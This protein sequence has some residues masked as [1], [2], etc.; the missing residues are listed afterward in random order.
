MG[1]VPTPFGRSVAGGTFLNEEAKTSTVNRLVN[2]IREAKP[3]NEATQAL[4][5]EELSRR[6]GRAAGVIEAGS[7]AQRFQAAKGQLVGDL[8]NAQFEPVMPQFHRQD[9]DSLYDMIAE[10]KLRPFEQINTADAL[11]KLLSGTIPTR[12]E[13]DKLEKVFGPELI[14]AVLSKRTLNE[15]AFE[16]IVDILNIPRTLATAFDASAPLRQGVILSVAHPK[17]AGSAFVSMFKAMARP[18]VDD[19]IQEAIENSPRY[20]LMQK[21]KLYLAPGGSSATLSAR[22]EAFMSRLINRI[23]VV[24]QGVQASERGYRTYLNKLRADVFTT[25][26]NNWEKDGLLTDQRAKKL[27]DFLNVAS[28]RGRLGKLE[29]AA[30]ILSIPFFAPRLLTSR[31]QVPL[32][33]F[34]RDK[35]VR[36]QVARDLTAFVGTGLTVLGI[37]HAA[38]AE[39]E[40][41]PRSSDFGKIKIGNQRIDFW[42]GFQPIARYTAQILTG[43]RKDSSGNIQGSFWEG[44]GRR[45]AFERFLR[46]KLSPGGAIVY[47]LYAGNTFMGDELESTPGFVGSEALKRA[48]PLFFQDLYDAAKH[49][50]IKG[51]LLATPAFFGASSQ[52]YIPSESNQFRNLF[53]KVTRQDWDSLLDHE[54][55]ALLEENPELQEAYEKWQD[56]RETL[57]A[58][59]TRTKY[60]RLGDPELVALARTNPALYRERAGQIVHDAGVEYDFAERNKLLPQSNYKQTPDQQAVQGYY[61]AIARATKNNGEVDYEL[62]EQLGTNYL[63][64]LDSK[65]REKVLAE[66]S[67]SKDPTYRELLEDRSKL[68]TYFNAPDE[69]FA[70]AKTDPASAAILQ[71]FRNLSD[72]R[73][74]VDQTLRDAGVPDSEILS[75]RSKIERELGLDKLILAARKEAISRDPATIL[76]LEKWGYKPSKELREYAA[77]LV[78]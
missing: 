49:E 23:P 36:Q 31:F 67:F 15:K 13:L 12:S 56:E 43:Q 29:D 39:V 25:I 17:E 51:M 1:S 74:Y 73:A 46:S 58:D 77:E 54:R 65:T 16:T 69:A 7:G 55:Y 47:D 18:S 35:I 45:N 41:D 11:T 68:T 53:E 78:E 50:G 61:D 32:A 38:G 37:A 4:R 76:L 42:G 30:G 52:T 21:S 10:S 5:S 2:L 48:A 70:I 20:D 64:R 66:I 24:G 75:S 57:M 34:E 28:G 27:A 63:D 22:E 26:T 71:E 62:Q 44:E 19:A 60:N 33:L 3:A 40:L 72:F 9:I 59:I 6:A 8:P 14:K